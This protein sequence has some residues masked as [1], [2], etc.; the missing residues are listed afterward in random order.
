MLGVFLSQIAPIYHFGLGSLD[1][2]KL[3][4]EI[5][6]VFPPSLAFFWP[7]LRRLI[8]AGSDLK[9]SGSS[10]ENSGS[11]FAKFGIFLAQ[12]APINHYGLGCLDK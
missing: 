4:G 2:C 11:S 6:T 3:V 9:T 8:T 12:I 1:N 7:R 5:E 10:S